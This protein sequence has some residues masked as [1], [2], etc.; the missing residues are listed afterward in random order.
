MSKK[1][2]G[3]ITVIVILLVVGLIWAWRAGTFNLSSNDGKD[4]Q[5]GEEESNSKNPS[6]APAPASGSSGA[7]TKKIRVIS[8]NGSEV[9]Q[10]GKQYLVKWDTATI[11]PDADIFVNLMRT[12][13]VITDP[14]KSNATGRE[15]FNSSAFPSGLPPEGIY[16]YTVP[17]SLSPGSYQVVILVGKNCN[18]GGFCIF[19]VGDNL[20]TIK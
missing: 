2:L 20:F 11:P 9:W 5:N 4:A 19:D 14:Y 13:S 3:I 12:N 18:T 17:Q 16:T 6:P 7:A 8:P 10:R 1:S 15:M